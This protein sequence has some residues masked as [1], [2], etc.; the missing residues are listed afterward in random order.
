MSSFPLLIR[1]LPTGRIKEEV[2]VL[3]RLLVVSQVVKGGGAQKIADGG[4]G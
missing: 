3:G 1:I 4:F 2:I